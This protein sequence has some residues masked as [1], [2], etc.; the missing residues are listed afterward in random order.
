MHATDNYISCKIRHLLVFVFLNY[1]LLL[2]LSSIKTI[3]ASCVYKYLFAYL[4]VSLKFTI[5]QPYPT[6]PLMLT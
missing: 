1:Q 5:L 4:S 6:P 3:G 2:S